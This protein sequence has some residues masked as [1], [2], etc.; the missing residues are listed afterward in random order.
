MKKFVN[1]VV[2]YLIILQC[3]Q[4]GTASA[5]IDPIHFTISTEES[6]VLLGQEFELTIR[7]KYMSI[8]PTAAFVFEGANEFTLKIILPDGF[9]R[10]GGTFQ[11][12]V[13][14][15]LSSVTPDLELTVKGKFVR[16]TE[17]GN[18]QLLRG[19]NRANNSSTF[20]QVGTLSFSLDDVEQSEEQAGNARIALVPQAKTIPYVSIAELRAGMADTAQVVYITD[21]GM[22]GMFRYSAESNLADDGAMTIVSAGRRY[23]RVY[24]GVVNVNW[25]GIVGDGVTNFS[26]KIQTLLNNNRYP[27]I[28]F[29]KGTSSYRINSIKIPSNKNLQFEEGTVV[30]GL[31]QLAEHERM[32][33]IFDVDNVTIKGYNVVFKDQ[34]SAYTSG[35]QKHIFVIQGSNNIIIEGLAAKNSGG[36]GF[37]IG[38]GNRQKF[39]ENVKLINIISDNNRRQGLSIVSGK[40]IEV[41]NPIISNTNGVAPGAG[42]D[43]EPNFPYEFLEGIRITNPKTRNNQG[44]AIMVSPLA[45]VGT[46]NIVDIVVSN[47]VDDGSH[48]GFLVTSA[49]ASL[50]GSIVNENPVYKNNKYS[51]FVARNWSSSACVVEINSPTVINA[52]TSGTTSANLGAAFLIYRAEND[53]GDQNMG[54]VHI[55]RP[56][57][58]DSRSIRKI[59]S[60]FVYIDLTYTGR[61]KNCTLLDPLSIVGLDPARYVTA[62]LAEVNISDKYF[63]LAQDF[64]QWNRALIYTAYKSMFHNQSSTSLKTLT[65]SKVIANFP[66]VTIEVRSPYIIRIIPDATD[67]ILPISPVNGKHLISNTVGSR[68]TLKKTLDNSWFVKEM[69]GTWTVQ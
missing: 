24:D 65:L 36:D 27:S 19:H 63:Q 50:A 47:H 45:L 31:G 28:F 25:F 53:I 66:E 32:V 26:N 56:R 34:K 16:Q 20:I 9:V 4:S 69:V 30:E 18:F 43:I 57:I 58:L 60:A 23:E 37:Y 5:H 29:P 42:I 51:G 6:G 64:G 48:Y 54:N 55:S 1:F 35:Q 10:T 67:N 12:L 46:E 52:N 3:C 39:S 49:T 62:S 15:K 21:S 14:F 59:T 17:N 13:P 40:N 44:P 22:Q 7:A 11:D 2:G 38:S 61:F 8:P 41:I 68:I 33:S